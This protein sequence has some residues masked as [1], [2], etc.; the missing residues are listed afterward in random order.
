MSCHHAVSLPSAL[1]RLLPGAST[2]LG[3]DY[4]GDDEEQVTRLEECHSAQLAAIRA[5][6]APPPQGVEWSGHQSL[7]TEITTRAPQEVDR[8]ERAPDGSGGDGS[9]SRSTTLA[10]RPH[11]GVAGSA[12]NSATALLYPRYHLPHHERLYGDAAWYQERSRLAVSSRLFA[13]PH[14]TVALGMESAR[15]LPAA[16]RWDVAETPTA[17]ALSSEPVPSAAPLPSPL[18]L[19]GS[20]AVASALAADTMTGE[21][22]VD[23]W[24]LDEL[25]AFATP[26]LE[27]PLA[28]PPAAQAMAPLPPSS[29][30]HRSSAG[31]RPAA[32][33]VSDWLDMSADRST[34]A[35]SGVDAS[36]IEPPRAPTRR[37]LTASERLLQ[38]SS[39]RRR[40]GESFDL[41]RSWRGAIVPP[42]P[43]D[44]HRRRSGGHGAAD[45]ADG[46][47]TPS[48][49]S[50]QHSA[51]FQRF[52]QRYS[53]GLPYRV[54][55]ALDRRRA[56]VP[57]VSTSTPSTSTS[58]ST[59]TSSSTSAY[60][61]QMEERLRLEAGIAS[62]AADG[63]AGGF[64]RARSGSGALAG[65]HDRLATS[66]FGAGASPTSARI[67][68]QLRATRHERPQQS[69]DS[70]QRL[71]TVA[72]AAPRAGDP[73]GALLGRREEER[74]YTGE[75]DGRSGM[76]R[77]PRRGGG[78]RPRDETQ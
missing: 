67:T 26:T 16:G 70:T 58:T 76:P 24:L 38:L 9:P 10:G 39:G 66:L 53:T 34:A 25:E 64:A 68:H 44:E 57:Q 11:R 46:S 65:E 15:R 35:L 45:R 20:A 23:T 41:D 3:R 51:R 2:W 8:S 29:M 56:T 60:R 49:A 13:E 50:A 22:D 74:R 55:N 14:S 40:S 33:D 78:A 63:P 72:A 71:A 59:S 30:P 69:G 18:P 42:M 47:A 54:R 17:T 1:P 52:T 73:R 6:P 36:L 12:A 5:L 4:P 48:T 62:A 19:T 37:H 61:L 7:G 75:T 27:E 43:N 21:P 77:L 31:S 28:A 32:L